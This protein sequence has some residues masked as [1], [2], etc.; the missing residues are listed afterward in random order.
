[1]VQI[2]RVLKTH[3]VGGEIVISLLPEIDWTEDIEFF[4]CSM[5]GI[6]VPFF[7]ENIRGRSSTTIIVKFDD[8]DTLDSAKLLQGVKVFLPKRYAVIDETLFLPNRYVGYGVNDKENGWLGSIEA[9]DES[10]LNVLFLVRSG[11]RERILPVNEE[12]IESID[13]ERRII[14][15]H[16]P[17]GVADL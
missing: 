12:W 4:V 5:D 6:L 2:G 13:E 7:I 10:T 8:I 14:H 17:E 16:L 9:V 1:M 15:F 11:E 3:G